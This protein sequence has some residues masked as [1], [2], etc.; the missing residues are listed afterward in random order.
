[1]RRVAF[2][3]VLASLMAAPALAADPVRPAPVI[4][5]PP[6]PPNYFNGLYL[7]LHGGW[8]WSNT[9]AEYVDPPANCGVGFVFGC[10]VD[11]EPQ[12]AFVGGQIGWNWAPNPNGLMLGIEGDYS[13]A[14]L[15]DSQVGVFGIGGGD[16][17][18]VNLDVKSLATIQARLGWVT[19]QMMPFLTIGYGWAQ[20]ERSAFNPVFLPVSGTLDKRTHKG[21]TL[22]FGGEF[23]I[24]EHWSV[25][26]E[27]RF[28]NGSTETYAL[29]FADGT[30]VD[31]DIHTARFGINWNF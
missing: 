9:T 31:L 10:P 25:K 7:G 14:S 5:V 28:F 8:G 30:Q 3:V 17:T 15:H 13:F 26:G 19:G 1:M 18:Q 12:G 29:G 27:Y 21:L 4:V 24:N 23:A 11:A 20:T 2:G 22:G 16:A 6:P